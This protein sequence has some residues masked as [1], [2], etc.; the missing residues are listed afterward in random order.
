MDFRNWCICVLA[1]GKGKRMK[2]SQPKILLPVLG[3][4]LINYLLELEIPEFCG[5][6]LAVV[7]PYYF[8]QVRSV[9]DPKVKLV[10]QD[11]PLGTAHAVQSIL[12]YLDSDIQKILVIYA[13]MPLLEP[14]TIHQ[15]MTFFEKNHAPVALL[16]TES[17]T[18]NG[19]G[20]VIRDWQGIPLKIVEES[21]CNDEE[22]KI[23]EI[24]LGIYAF[25][26]NEIETVLHSINRN[27]IQGEYY[28]TDVL[29][30]AKNLNFEALVYMVPWDTQFINVNSSDELS[31]VIGILRKK[32]I[33][34]LF[35]SGVKIIDPE[36]VYVDWDA[37]CDKDVW[38]FPGT[39]IEGQCEIGENTK[40]GPYTHLIN[41]R[42]GKNCRI[43]YSIVEDSILE[44]EVIIGPFTHIRM[45]SYIK[46]NARIGNF[47]EVKKSEI[48]E[49]TK[50]LHHSYLGDARLGKKVNIGAGTITCNYDGYKKHPTIIHD[51]VFIGSNNSLVAPVTIGE[52]AYTAAG[53]TITQDVPPRALGVGRARQ[54][55]IDKWVER[56]KNRS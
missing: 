56:K 6:R 24:N 5:R 25:Q 44:D 32:K 7:S 33:N 12:P 1:A 14:V 39:I 3:K 46:K 16:S 23:R 13:D 2:S 8:D 40:V 34:Q 11:Q 48:G 37:K 10:T 51:Q 31:T 43:E 26:K 36:S 18:P 42:I 50:A 49:E 27:N 29:E 21:D 9:I 20:R 17:E 4:P 30:T 41:S 35:D 15:F 54:V 45:N 52:G 22:K 55:N 53:S 38:L 28:L 47:V 19:F